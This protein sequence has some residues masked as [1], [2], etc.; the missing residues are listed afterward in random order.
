MAVELVPLDAARAM[1]D[2]DRC[3]HMTELI[4]TLWREEP[5]IISVCF[6]GLGSSMA[7]ESWFVLVL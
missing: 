3:V 1:S 2:W 4:R 6:L 5:F 7:V